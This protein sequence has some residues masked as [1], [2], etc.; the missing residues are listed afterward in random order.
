LADI[1]ISNPM[2]TAYWAINQE[3]KETYMSKNLTRKGIAFG[4]AV[5]LGTTLFTGAP[6]LAN[7][8]VSIAPSA[9]TGNTTILG[10]NFTVKATIGSLVPASAFKTLKFR[11]TNSAEAALT[12]AAETTSQ[13]GT[14]TRDGSAASTSTGTSDVVYEANAGES[15]NATGTLSIK[16]SATVAT[17]VTV[18]AFLDA[19]GGDD[20]DSGEIQTAAYEVKFVKAADAGI[21]TVISQPEIGDTTLKAT[22]TSSIINVGQIGTNNIR[23]QFGKYS[24]STAAIAEQTNTYTYGTLVA[25]DTDADSGEKS[26]L[27][28]DTEA[29]RTVESNTVVGNNVT[30]GSFAAQAIWS[31]IPGTTAYVKIG[32]ESVKSA[33]AAKVSFLGTDR[34]VAALTATENVTSQGIIRKDYTGEVVLT[35]TLRDSDKK[36]LAGRTV[37]L[38][39]DDTDTVGTFKING[40][41]VSDTAT[42]D[43]TFEVV[44]DAS[45]IA[46]FV[47]SSSTAAA[48]SQLDVESLTSEGVNLLQSF[49]GS[50]LRFDW[51]SATYTAVHKDGEA[52]TR[53]VNKG[54]AY[55]FSVLVVDQ[56]KKP[57]TSAAYRIQADVTGRSVTTLYGDLSAG[58][59][60]FAIADGALASDTATVTFSAWQ[61][62]KSTG[63]TASSPDI[64]DPGTAGTLTLNYYT[65]TD[66]VALEKDGTASADLSARAALNA[67]VAVDTRLSNSAA[68]TFV[69]SGANGDQQVNITGT[70][71]HASTGVLKAGALV[72]VSGDASILFNVG[73]VFAFGSLTYFDADGT[74]AINAYSN[75]IQS[76]SVVT[77]AAGGVSTTTAISFTGGPTDIGTVLEISAPTYV[78][79]GSTLQATIKVL[80]K[81]GNGVD[82]DITATDWDDSGSNGGAAAGEDDVP[83]EVSYSGP[84]I[85][86]GA[87]LPTATGSDGTAKVSAL[88]GSTETGS[89]TIS[90]KYAGA[91]GVLGGASTDDLTATKIIGVGTAPAALATANVAGSTKRFFVSVDGNTSARNVVVKVAGKTFRTLKGS[92]AKKSYAVAA[93]K[94]THKVTVF[95]GGKLIA[96]RTISVK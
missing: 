11:V 70:V 55:N 30:A 84:G 77:V 72:T 69:T 79:A 74:L 26:V 41:S 14:L 82:T 43:A 2:R 58:A 18:V 65:Q 45:G 21:T 88:L 9:G 86:F 28:V 44:S 81:F 71:K 53:A 6:A 52:T 35:V 42:T 15:V 94:G 89:I 76:G 78:Q 61:Q 46:K 27:D 95:V 37:R 66:V 91:D 60:T 75:K 87:G 54:S 93:P 33:A 57:L 13:T 85:V 56:W 48:T 17:S 10:E 32:S 34:S 8:G 23:V 80:D 7:T 20:L 47:V 49:T 92:T 25:T 50:A 64:A 67:T 22:I 51:N 62:N 29:E 31:P 90:V 24:G 40:K 19:D 38:V 59:A 73:N 5:A 1:E 39:H 16:T 36:V 4:A 63:W 68:T 12:Y 96:T 83:F 3:K